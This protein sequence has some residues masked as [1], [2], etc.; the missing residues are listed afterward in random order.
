MSYRRGV[1]STRQDRLEREAEQAVEAAQRRIQRAGS[2]VRQ[3]SRARARLATARERFDGATDALEAG[4]VDGANAAAEDA[5]E[6]ARQ[7][8]DLERQDGGTQARHPDGGLELPVV[9]QVGV[10]EIAIAIGAGLLLL[11]GGGDEAAED[12]DGDGDMTVHSSDL[13]DPTEFDTWQAFAG[14]VREAGGSFRDASE[15]W[16]G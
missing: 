9:G 12:V 5:A 15:M 11:G 7:A 6:L 3:D 4:D 8:V 10:A 2:I 13:P 14:A 1:S 16:T